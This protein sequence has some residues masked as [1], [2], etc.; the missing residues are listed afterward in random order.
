MVPD[1]DAAIDAQALSVS[2]GPELDKVPVGSM[3]PIDVGAFVGVASR[4]R[5]NE[6]PWAA[7]AASSDE[8]AIH[9]F[10]ARC[11]VGNRVVTQKG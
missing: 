10:M 2:M 6:F 3:F 11:E 8:N 4:V 1:T 9:D 7:T 5:D